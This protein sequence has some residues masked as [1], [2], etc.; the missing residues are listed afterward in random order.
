MDSDLRARRREPVQHSGPLVVQRAENYVVQP[1]AF[2][3]PVDVPG[4][5]VVIAASVGAALLGVVGALLSS[6]PNSVQQ[7][8][9]QRSAIWTIR[10]WPALRRTATASPR[11]AVS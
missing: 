8:A 9:S 10:S 7:L 11:T 2:K 4:A 3:K 5:L 6:R 1:R